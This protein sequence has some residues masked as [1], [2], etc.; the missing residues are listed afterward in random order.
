MH[1]THT[2]GLDLRV[3]ADTSTGE[4]M[5]ERGPMLE[6]RVVSD[7]HIR[8][9]LRS[10]KEIR[11]VKIEGPHN[12]NETGIVATIGG[13]ELGLNIEPQNLTLAD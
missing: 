3:Q 13:L 2:Y 4:V 5:I 1:S 6:D 11:D 8:A 7:D 10:V 12:W 9:A